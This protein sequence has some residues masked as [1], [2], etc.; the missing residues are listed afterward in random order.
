MITHSRETTV[1]SR[2]LLFDTEPPSAS[3]QP[4]AITMS[5]GLSHAVWHADALGSSHV[6]G[7]S[8]GHARLDRELPGGGWPPSALTE[9]LWPQHGGGEFRLLAPVLAALSAAGKAIILLAPPI[10]VFAPAMAQLG[11]DLKSILL[12]RS[13]KPADRLWATEQILKSAHFGAL[14]CWLPQARHDHLRRLQLAAGNTEGLNF[15]FRP[16]AAQGE[17]SPAPLRLLCQAGP[18]GQ[19]AVDV[20]K[21][22]GPAASAP[23]MLDARLPRA[24]ARHITRKT[25]RANVS[26]NAPASD[27]TLSL[28]AAHA[29]DRPVPAPTAA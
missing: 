13:E 24:I 20:I 10:Q 21:R 6:P 22:R 26:S 1:H 5:L 15:V 29:V 3:A 7:I 19:I 18:G 17:S 12:V 16:A 2:S 27:I 28:D 9:L 23:V 11:I 4:P 25:G 8:T 14:L